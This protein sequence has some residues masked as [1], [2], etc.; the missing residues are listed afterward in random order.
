MFGLLRRVGVVHWCPA[1]GP[2]IQ[3]WF[4]GVRDAS[5]HSVVSRFR[6]DLFGRALLV[7]GPVLTTT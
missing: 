7:L 1:L 3:R 6:F 5:L 4:Y 2:L